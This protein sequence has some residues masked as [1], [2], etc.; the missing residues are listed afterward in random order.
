M[1]GTLTITGKSTATRDLVRAM[2]CQIVAFH[3]PK[4]VRCIA[5]FPAGAANEWNWL[6]WLPHTQRL[7]HVKATKQ[8]A[9]EPYSLLA[10]NASDFLE[11]LETQVRPELEL[12]RKLSEV[13]GADLEQYLLPHLIFII[14][15]FVLGSELAQTPELDELFRDAAKLGVT[16]LCLVNERSQEPTGTQARIAISD[17]G[18]LSF[19]VT[20][21][22]GRRMTGITPNS[23]NVQLCEHIARNLAVLTLA[24]QEA[25]GD[26]S[27][28]IRLLDLLN[29][30]APEAI[31]PA[32][33]WIAREK[34]AILRIPIGMREKGKALLLDLKEAAEKG[35]GPHGLVVGA[36]G[37]G[38]SELLR[39]L[40]ISQAI[41]H[42]PSL[43][44]FVFV[45]FKGGASFA[46]L[47]ALPHVAGMITN[48]E[49]EPTLIDRMHASLLGELRRR[50]QI[51][52]E[53]GNLDNIQQYRLL[54]QTR[55]NTMQP[56][57][58]LLLIVDE[59][60][61]LLTNRPDFLELFVTIGRVGRSLG[62]HLL[63][64]T[65]RLEEGRL[66]GLESYLRYRICLR[67]FSAAESAAVL[68]KADAY[69]LPSAPGIGYIKID[70]NTPQ[71]FKTA[72]ISMPYVPANQQVSASDFVREFTPTGRIVP[73][74]SVVQS[75]PTAKIAETNQTEMD[76]TIA[77][78]AASGQGAVHQVWLPPLPKMLDLERI[79]GQAFT[80]SSWQRP[81]LFGM[82]RV[83]IGLLDVPLEQAQVPLILD[84][85]GAGGHL[86]IVGAPQSGKSM[87][88]RTLITSFALTHSPRDVQIYCIDLGGGL[89]RPLEDLPHVGAVCTQADREKIR[90]L[91]RL[92]YKVIADR[93]VLFRD[94][95][96][97]SMAMY[98]N[99]R[100]KGELADFPFG[101]VFLVIDNLAQL[102]H[103]FEQIEA[104]ITNIVATGLTY[105]VH[106]I[107]A[108]NRWP[109]IRPKLRDNMGTRLEL[110]LNDPIESEVDKRK[111]AE[112][113]VGV[114]GR[115]LT[116]EKLQFQ[117]CLPGVGSNGR[118]NVSQQIL[119]L[120]VEQ[121]KVWRGQVASPV[122][123]LPTQIKQREMLS[124]I[125]EAI[126]GV[127]LGLE[128]FRLDIASLDLFSAG[129]HLLILGDPECGKTNLLRLL[130]S[131]LM[132]R[133]SP[134][135]VKI[136]A[137]ECR[138]TTNFF[139]ITNSEHFLTY[140]SMRMP[141]SL[142]DSVDFL[143]S[144]LKERSLPT[145]FQSIKDLENAKT[146]SGPH[147]F[148]FVD[149]YD[150][151]AS[152][153]G[154]A[155]S[156]LRELIVQARDIGFHVV[157]TRTVSGVSSMSFE[158]LF[159]TLREMGGP[160]L[161]MSGDRQEGKLL[162]D[163]F[164]AN[165][166]P[167]RGYLVQRKQ[168]PTLVQVALV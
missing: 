95:H 111:S 12:R 107:L 161:I 108:S 167:G 92:M 130:I 3:T 117:A 137:I 72:L 89:L 159:K 114:P 49:N 156:P 4:E 131:E 164:A 19:A 160:G 23:A 62:L 57:P 73:C 7:R 56:L 16:I 50:Q 9:A 148:L 14:D 61:E 75:S 125:K 140:G 127:P 13:Q 41:L 146:W 29:I 39:T 129:P 122:L 6:K 65:Q 86:A 55:R 43:V 109:E 138:S 47:A 97:E 163:Q 162:H 38:K 141:A 158:P 59:F 31:R 133:Y 151:I 103:D 152:S 52:R 76:I 168:P 144:K 17:R 79:V 132:R 101:D 134:E 80:A 8:L 68:G 83:P 63:L 145:T 35:D 106:I 18:W 51:L 136:A 105:G 149:D 70:A 44:N 150:A 5:C 91:L 36:T 88:L 84:F 118:D 82:L 157:L 113:P 15:S 100:Q 32:K 120:L 69:Y 26:L 153:S 20:K 78:L 25:Q 147:Y 123:M 2:L 155:L 99:S 166:P 85:G 45:D 24:N 112:L 121:A 128:E 11:I 21:F 37:S 135:Q 58:H 71:R 1:I 74:Q 115:G 33:T 60:A 142:K 28:D 42:D 126:K 34:A 143:T 119:T 67:T 22:D 40:V 110:R 81:P 116:K 10:D 154:S 165:Q 94:H 66:K 87:L 90:L 53:A 102:Q 46:D 98:R 54:W 139:H 93:Q 104:E 48:L 77:H 30:S 96:I 27:Q 64:A 124:T